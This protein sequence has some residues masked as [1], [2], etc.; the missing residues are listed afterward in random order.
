MADSPLQKAAQGL[1]GLLELKVGGHQPIKFGE[2]I[3]PVIDVVEFYASVTNRVVKTAT[4]SLNA[5]NTQ[6]TMQVP[7]NEI[8]RLHTLGW[9]GSFNA[10]S[11]WLPE[12]LIE[13]D[14]VGTRLP[15]SYVNAV[16]IPAAQD[17]NL[18]GGVIFDAPLLLRS[19]TNLTVI[20]GTN[21]GA[22]TNVTLRALVDV[23]P[24]S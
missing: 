24:N 16:Q 4:S 18:N 15:N 12:M 2:T 22:A 14:G 17:S 10:L 1:T 21:I 9:H 20:A 23:I 11:W 7:I 13:I 3:L 5:R 19:G 8:W 6:T